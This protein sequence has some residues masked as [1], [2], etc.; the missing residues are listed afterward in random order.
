MAFAREDF[1]TVLNSLSEHLQSPLSLCIHTR[2]YVQGVCVIHY[3]ATNI[4]YGNREASSPILSQSPPTVY[5]AQPYVDNRDR[6]K[7]P[8]VGSAGA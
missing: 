7:G 6:G 1:H 2:W 4:K 8:G 5:L 3:P